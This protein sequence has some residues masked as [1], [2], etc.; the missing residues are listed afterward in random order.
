[1]GFKRAGCD[2]NRKTIKTGEEMKR[3]QKP[4]LK[5]PYCGN[6]LL[7]S[8]PNT[9]VIIESGEIQCMRCGRKT[10]LS[11]IRYGNYGTEIKN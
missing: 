9:R 11:N 6:D 5:C 8:L 7:V 3:K 1:M 10:S 4:A 2:Y